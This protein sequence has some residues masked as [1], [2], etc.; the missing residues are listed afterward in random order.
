MDE[1]PDLPGI[2]EL[3]GISAHHC[4]YCDGFE[5]AGKKVAAFGKG[6][7]GADLAV[8]MKHWV[9]DV[10]VCTD[11]K[12]ISDQAATKLKRHVSR[13]EPSVFELFRQSQ[14]ISRASLLKAVRISSALHSF[15]RLVAISRPTFPK[16]SG[17]KGMRKAA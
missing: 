7:K 17:A 11:G 2:H 15:S 9:A 8:M 13:S 4:L 6:D 5:Y 14:G 10:V 3:Y 1:M 12:T 16:T